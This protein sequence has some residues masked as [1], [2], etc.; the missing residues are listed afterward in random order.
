MFNPNI[1]STH[2]FGAMLT[3][4]NNPFAGISMTNPSSYAMA[5]IPPPSYYPMSDTVNIGYY[6]SDD[7]NFSYN[8]EMCYSK[9]YNLAKINTNMDEAKRIIQTMKKSFLYSILVP[10]IGS[11]DPSHTIDRPAYFIA[12]GFAVDEA[13]L[14]QKIADH[15]TRYGNG[16]TLIRLY[17]ITGAEERELHHSLKFNQDFLVKYLGMRMTLNYDMPKGISGMPKGLGSAMAAQNISEMY[18]LDVHLIGFLDNKY[19]IPI[20]WVVNFF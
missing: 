20:E 4:N 18:Y 11:N 8:S 2:T 10:I 1:F 5:S 3:Q 6:D 14:R 7:G 16:A 12:M 13:T 15:K 17:P 19:K 9:E